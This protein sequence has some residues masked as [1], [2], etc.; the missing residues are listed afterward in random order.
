M[1]QFEYETVVAYK[2]D[3]L[4]QRINDRLNKGW[5]LAGN[6]IVTN[7]KSIGFLQPMLREKPSMGLLDNLNDKEADE[8]A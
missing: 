4:D 8:N 3:D 2:L 6:L 1:K 7:G 5:Q